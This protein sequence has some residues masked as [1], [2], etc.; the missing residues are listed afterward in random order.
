MFVITME[1]V[2][3]CFMKNNLLNQL[4]NEKTND[5]AFDCRDCSWGFCTRI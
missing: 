3:P 2:N 1:Q 5:S 4:K